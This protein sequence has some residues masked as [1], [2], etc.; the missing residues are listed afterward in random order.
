MNGNT[1]KTI[2]AGIAIAAVAALWTG[3]ARLARVEASQ[4][5]MTA[6]MEALAIEMQ[7]NR[8]LL[9]LRRDGSTPRFGER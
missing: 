9:F 6:Q 7:E 4:V 2:A 3:N 5:H 8:R 1:W